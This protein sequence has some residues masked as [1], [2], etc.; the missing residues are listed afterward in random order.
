M[1]LDSDPELIDIAIQRPPPVFDLTPGI[2]LGRASGNHS[3]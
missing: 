3:S 2:H 1:P